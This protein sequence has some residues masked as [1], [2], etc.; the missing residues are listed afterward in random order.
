MGEGQAR[1]CPE[2]TSWLFSVPQFPLQWF[3]V[4]A[5]LKGWFE[6]VLVA[7]FAYTYATMYDKGPFKVGEPLG[8]PDRF[9]PERTDLGGMHHTALINHM[10]DVL[11]LFDF[12]HSL[13]RYFM[14]KGIMPVC[15][16][17]CVIHVH[18]A[19]GVQQRTSDPHVGA[20]N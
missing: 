18:S 11:D 14:Y 17:V 7:E 13:M 15:M 6:R 8:I 5:I 20:G 12:F 9:Y 2:L 1:E 16:S 4:P 19:Q 10:C 3:G